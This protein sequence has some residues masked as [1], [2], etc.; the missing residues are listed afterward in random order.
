MKTTRI[1][2]LLIN[3]LYY[4]LIVVITGI[5]LFYITVLFFSEHLPS[6]LRGFGMIFSFGWKLLILPIITYINFILFIIAINYLKK[7][8]KPFLKSN[9]YS[10]VVIKSLKKAGVLFLF[11][12]I[13]MILLELFTSIFIQN[14]IGFS[15]GFTFIFS[16][17]GAIDIHMV[18]LIIIAL[19]LLLF[20]KAF[21][22][23]KRLQQENDSII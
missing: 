6:P 19:F 7:C 13:S 8:V 1:L 16:F 21:E 14:T 12:G 2:N 15:K 20:S 23:S 9:F 5:T 22:N 17:I 11:I 3:L 10:K 18:F 4:A